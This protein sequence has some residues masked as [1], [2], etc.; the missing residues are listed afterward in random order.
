MFDFLGSAKWGIIGGSLS[1]ILLFGLQPL[2]QSMKQ[3]L[4]QFRHKGY[5]TPLSQNDILWLNRSAVRLAAEKSGAIYPRWVGLFHNGVLP[6]LLGMGIWFSATYFGLRAFV[7]A[8]DDTALSWARLKIGVSSVLSIF[9]GIF[10]AAFAMITAAKH[11]PILRDYLIYHYGWGYAVP[12]PRGEAEIK[13]ELD[14][15]LRSRVLSS[16]T[17]YDNETLSNFIFNRTTPAWRIW[18]IGI[19]IVTL[20][21]FILDCRY[22]NTLYKDRIEINPY[23]SL[24]QQTYTIADIAHVKRRCTLA[25]DKAVHYPNFDFILEMNNGTQMNVLNTL[26][27][28]KEQQLRALETLWPRIPSSRLTSTHVKTALIVKLSPTLENCSRLLKQTQPPNIVEKISQFF[29]LP[30]IQ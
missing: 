7:P 2:L 10:L 11:S 14:H 25:V 15:L 30:V 16:E 20:G 4:Y 3:K 23:F 24:R 17:S 1:I 28:K 21:F 26:G 22:Y 19:A 9:F 13:D 18:T 6:C 5:S 12:H 29:N 8:I 27:P